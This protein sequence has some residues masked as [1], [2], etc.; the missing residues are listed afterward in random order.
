MS[1]IFL[2]G[3]GFDVLLL[4]F[5]QRLTGLY[6]F[7]GFGL[8]VIGRDLVKPFGVD[9]NYSA[10]VIFLGEHEFMVEH[11]DG[12]VGKHAAGMDGHYL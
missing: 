6:I 7:Y 10:H 4:H 8:K 12:L 1:L 3:N 2:F 9:I 11:E 5:G